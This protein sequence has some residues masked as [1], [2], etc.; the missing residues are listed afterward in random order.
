[1]KRKSLVQILTPPSCV[2]M[3]KKKKKK[4]V[5]TSCKIVVDVVLLTISVYKN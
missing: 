5:S 2:D 4:H 1:M 3:S